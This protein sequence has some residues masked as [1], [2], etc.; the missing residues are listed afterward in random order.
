[1]S[2]P[3]PPAAVSPLARRLFLARTWLGILHLV[4]LGSGAL[5]AEPARDPGRDFDLQG[6]ID[7]ALTAGQKLVRVPPG[8]Y[9]VRPHR[10]QHLVLQGLEDV[11]IDCTG[12]E[13]ICTETTRAV[14]IADCKRLTLRGLAVD[15]DPLPFT[16]GRITAL[17]PDKK[18]H[19]VKLFPGYPR[20][21]A[22]RNEKYEVFRPDTR[23]LRRETPHIEKLEVVDDAHLRLTKAGGGPTD[24]EEV[25]DIVVINAVHA[26]GG[27]AAHAIDCHDCDRVVLEDVTV[28]ASNC[29]G[30]LEHDCE[31]TV[32]RRCRYD[33]RP[34]AT[35]LA[36]REPRIRS[37]NADAFHSKHA[38]I[39]PRYLECVARFMGD[40]A[41]N[42]CGDYHLVMASTGTSLRVLA[43]R[44]MNLEVGADVEL[45]D[46][47][48]RRLADARVA[49]IREAASITPE[50][51]HW[52]APQRMDA[53]LRTNTGGLLTK[54]YEV[55]LDREVAL[56][57]GSVIASTRRM[58]NG[59]VIDRC[60]FGFNRSRGILIKASR[61]TITDCILEGSWICGILVAP[62]WW[63]LES[64]SSSDLTITGNRIANCPT[65]GI[66][67]QAR[68]G[69]GRVS[70]AGGHRNI[71][72]V[73]NSF[74][75]VAFP[76]IL[77]TSTAGL[78][79]SDNR[80]PEA[81]PQA[82]W[83]SGLVPAADR[84]KPVVMVDCFE[85]AKP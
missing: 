24:P 25:G 51:A 72:I 67:V 70:P 6:F 54:G 32:Y 17:S 84:G 35:D 26:P 82:T 62:E 30:F 36:A 16:Q 8:R 7:S 57:R 49:A 4:S 75:N 21:P 52:L 65:P 85:A 44:D 78:E 59:F 45:F 48:G 38:R 9:R 31:A 56:P 37:G 79:L 66:V 5:A 81:G 33:R 20:A 47:D 43:K 80:F 27:F 2:A 3:A 15:Y 69:N 10:A 46:Y 55:D 29:F 76:C 42:I 41:V 64:G 73:G 23:V 18:I 63:W 1:M 68:G 74:T 77:C 83:E 53:G 60:T 14:T 34:P 22:A 39:G 61:G 71:R 19:D 40:D 28:H 58:G 50:E 11:V 13:M 12:V